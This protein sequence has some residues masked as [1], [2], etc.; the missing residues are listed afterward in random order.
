MNRPAGFVPVRFRIMGLIILV[1]GIIGL[2]AAVVG[3]I[4]G[5]LPISPVL[6]PAAA[7]AI[8]VGMYLIFI[9]PR[10]GADEDR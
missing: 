3:L 2:A 8:L 1:A 9:V 5:W 10:T 7:V 4:T 6:L